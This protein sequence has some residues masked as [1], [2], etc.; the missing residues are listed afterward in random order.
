MSTQRN[1]EASQQNGLT[2]QQKQRFHEN[3]FLFVWSILPN[4]ALQPLISDSE[5]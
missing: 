1:S 2:A 5:S 3:G 4:E